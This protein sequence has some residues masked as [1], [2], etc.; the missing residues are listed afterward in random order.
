MKVKWGALIVAGSGGAGGH[1]LSKNRGG[2]YLRTKVTPLNPSSNDQV[3]VRNNFTANAQG[4][5]G[6]T[7]A[8][9]KDWNTSVQNFIGTDVF[10]DSKVLSGFQLY[11]RLNNYLRFISETPIV[12]PPVPASVPTFATF[13]AIPDKTLGDCEIAFTPAIA[14]T[15]KVIIS[16]TPGLSAGVSFVKS[17]YRKITI[18]DNADVTPYD[19]FADYETKFGTFPAVGTKIFFRARQIIIASGLP[20][21]VAQ[22]SAIVV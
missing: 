22:C 5:K 17:E 2:A 11:V 14:A 18:M 1:I 16:A 3:A 15:E 8:Q 10:G 13:S 6:L 9:R 12:S 4:W 19:L 7:V 21:A 20:G